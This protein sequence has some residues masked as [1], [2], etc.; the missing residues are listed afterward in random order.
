MYFSI[1]L[2]GSAA[3]LVRADDEVCD[4]IS[5]I[6]SSFL[7]TAAAPGDIV[8][9]FN[10]CSDVGFVPGS[11]AEGGYDFVSVCGVLRDDTV[12]AKLTAALGDEMDTLLESVFYGP[13]ES[14]C[15]IDMVNHVLRAYTTP[16]S[17]LDL[18][19]T[20]TCTPEP[21]AFP[22]CECTRYPGA[23]PFSLGQA[24]VA[25]ADKS[26]T[27]Y[28]FQLQ[29]K[30]LASPQTSCQKTTVIKKLE[31]WA[32]YAYRFKVAGVSY[33]LKNGTTGAA[34]TS[35]ANDG[36]NKG[37]F[38]ITNLNWPISAVAA[39]QPKICI[40]L[41]NDITLDDFCDGDGACITSLFDPT[42]N[43]CPTYVSILY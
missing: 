22:F 14:T 13:D 4:M 16:G 3:P 6:V 20:T 40:T 41:K 31:V 9:G 36:P 34:T 18:E 28:C 8:S 1:S 30:A 15:S 32:V 39:Q 23:T 29:A 35:W 42:Q 7:A 26:T 5:G 43:C 25:V 10:A 11:G 19:A 2:P 37:T 38:K 12:G 17:C 21:T 27:Q 24:V 33:V